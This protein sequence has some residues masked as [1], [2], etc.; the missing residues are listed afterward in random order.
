MNKKILFIVALIILITIMSQTIIN[1]GNNSDL[2]FDTI[3]ELEKFISNNSEIMI[4]KIEVEKY[5]LYVLYHIEVNGISFTTVEKNEKYEIVDTS[6]KM[7]LTRKESKEIAV[8]G[9][10]ENELIHFEFMFTKKSVGIPDDK[11]LS[12]YTLLN[13]DDA[14]LYYRIVEYPE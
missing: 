7:G 13:F 11:D 6:Q 9:T 14:Q 3:K 1:N 4:K 10:Y 2:S 8:K 12:E 5:I